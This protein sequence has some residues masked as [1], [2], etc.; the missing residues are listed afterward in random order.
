MNDC[1]SNFWK[2]YRDGSRTGKKH[3]VCCAKVA[4]SKSDTIA[5]CV[6]I[7]FNM[8]IAGLE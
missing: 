3:K 8:G 6:S 4:E 1:N 7:A 2:L 5:Q